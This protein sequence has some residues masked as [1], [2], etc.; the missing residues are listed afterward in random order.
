MTDEELMREALKALRFYAEGEWSD[1][2]PGGI[3]IRQG[4]DIAL[5]FGETARDAIPKLQERLLRE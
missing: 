3:K 5:D 1:G 2:Y 4:N